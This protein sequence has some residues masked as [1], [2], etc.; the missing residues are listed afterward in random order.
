MEDKEIEKQMSYLTNQMLWLIQ[1][2]SIRIFFGPVMW[3]FPL[4]FPNENKLLVR[5]KII[6]CTDCYKKPVDYLMQ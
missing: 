1:K 2:V 5:N 4:F 3:A 6:V